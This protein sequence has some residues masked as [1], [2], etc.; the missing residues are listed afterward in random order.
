MAL[1]EPM[2][3]EEER[4]LFYC[5]MGLALAAW[6][7]VEVHLWNVVAHCFAPSEKPI[8]GKAFASVT[9]LNSKLQFA[10]GAITRALE[11]AER[12]EAYDLWEILKE[13]IRDQSGTR[14]NLAHG[15]VG[16]F[17]A[18]ARPGERIA[19][20]KWLNKKRRDKTKRPEGSM[21]LM[22]LSRA[23]EEFRSLSVRLENFLAFAVE[24]PEP[25]PKS[26]EQVDIPQTIPQLRH[27]MR[28][29]LGDPPKSS[30]ELRRVIDELNAAASLHTPASEGAINDNA[31]IKAAT[32]PSPTE[33]QVLRQMLA[34]PPDPKPA[35]KKKAP[36]RTK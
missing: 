10:N 9:G 34:R 2:S 24:Q 35:P 21:N 4:A 19:L 31:Q 23:K 25:H 15:Q 16:E 22:A 14:N 12:R 8:I 28:A 32:A 7:R 20:C 26:A 18:D 13:D 6:V 36:K 5:E 30:R 17:E 27:Q 3:M 33:D 1:P 11:L 29:A